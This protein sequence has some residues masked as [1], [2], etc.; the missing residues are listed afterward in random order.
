MEMVKQVHSSS[1]H[2]SNK[3]SQNQGNNK[4]SES[5]QEKQNL[6]QSLRGNK[7]GENTSQEIFPDFARFS[8]ESL[9]SKHNKFTN[10]KKHS[11]R[12]RKRERA[13]KQ[14]MLS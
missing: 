5:K 8:N 7:N 4:F 14:K 3:S 1:Q 2:I 13:C 6:Q 10:K 11:E 12:E 9:V